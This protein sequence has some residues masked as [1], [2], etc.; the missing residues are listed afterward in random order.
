VRDESAVRRALTGVDTVFHFAAAV[1]VGQSM[2][3][4]AEYTS[5]NNLGTANLLEVLSKQQG[6]RLVVAS[7]MSVYGE[8]L[9]RDANE[10][11]Y[12]QVERRA[13]DLLRGEWEP[14]GPD[15]RRLHP[16]PTPE[17]KPP[18][19]ASVYALSKYDQ[20]R[21]SLIVGQAYSIP[22]VALRFFNVYGS[23]HALSNPY[24][25]VLANFA[26]RQLNGRSPMIFEDGGQ[27][28]DFVHVRDVC[29]ACYLAATRDAAVGSVFN[30][31]SGRAI[32]IQEVAARIG[33][34]LGSTLVP[35]ITRKYR[36]GDIRHC[37]ADIRRA[38]D[39]LGYQPQVD[40][41]Q[42]LLELSEWL[43]SQVAI[44]RSD[45]MR[46]ELSERGLTL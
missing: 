30:I 12:T 10:V 42:G 40:F 46:V 34:Q 20:E 35:E 15:G 29:R 9:Y 36:A 45:Q 14:R 39:V 21:M 13:E 19:L 37:Y 28:R 33:A 41:D 27:K 25:G 6:V 17:D 18:R 24:T 11:E 44:D 23:R 31:G 3:Q 43:R 4:I 5:V 26:A 7:S 22:T 16:A 1:G 2:Y 38:R 8:G 32:E